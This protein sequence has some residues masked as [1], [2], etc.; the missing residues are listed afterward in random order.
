MS[1]R[2]SKFHNIVYIVNGRSNILNK[3]LFMT[4]ENGLTRRD[5][6]KTFSIFV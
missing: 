1:Y 3:D 5:F 6:E 2:T 4:F